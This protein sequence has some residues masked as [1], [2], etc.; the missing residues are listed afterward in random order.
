M[1]VGELL[2]CT[3]VLQFFNPSAFARVGGYPGSSETQDDAVSII[4]NYY[5]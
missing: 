5:A 2:L 1:H 3:N 4:H